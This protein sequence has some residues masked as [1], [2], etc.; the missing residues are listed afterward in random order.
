MA[1]YMSNASMTAYAV[2]TV[3]SIVWLVRDIKNK[4]DGNTEKTNKKSESSHL[5]GQYNIQHSITTL[6][7]NIGEVTGLSS[8]DIQQQR[9]VESDAIV[10]LINSFK[11]IEANTQNQSAYVKEVSVSTQK[12][13]DTDGGKPY[14]IEVKD[15]V[16]TLVS[17]IAETGKSGMT[18]VES[19][20]TMQAQIEEIEKMLVEIE[21][22]SRQTNLLS[23]NAAIEAARA[24]ENGRGFAVV[25]DEVRSLSMRSSEFAGQIGGQ[26]ELMKDT[27]KQIGM[28]VGTLVS[29]DLDVTL[30]TQKRVGEIVEDLE[31]LEVLTSNRL[32]EI[33]SIAQTIS[34][35]VDVAVRSL[36]FEDIV[37]QITERVESRVLVVG[38]AFDLVS[39][40]LVDA[41]ADTELNEHELLEKMNAMNSRL[42]EVK[43]TTASVQQ[44]SMQSDD[45]ELF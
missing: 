33:S 32:K 2:L 8:Q 1:L 31:D 6:R 19:L 38:D 28:V 37:R 41:G 11:G 12:M 24:G 44:K 17:S 45:V 29:S 18:L 30:G 16:E 15:I 21:S 5:L 39:Q 34:S 4:A 40:M 7:D 10:S 36:Q 22:I 20:N 14:L 27:M 23:L 9:S 13:K 43:N 35:D 42:F 26:H 25:A 3:I